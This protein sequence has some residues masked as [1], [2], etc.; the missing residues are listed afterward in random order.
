[1]RKKILDSFT[2]AILRALRRKKK[3]V[4]NQVIFITIATTSMEWRLAL[5]LSTNMKVILIEDW[6]LHWNTP[7]SKLL[8][9]QICHNSI[10]VFTA[11]TTLVSQV[12]ILTSTS[13]SLSCHSSL[14]TFLAH[15]LLPSSRLLHKCPL[16]ILPAQMLYP[17]YIF[18]LLLLLPHARAA[19]SFRRQKTKKILNIFLQ[20]L[21]GRARKRAI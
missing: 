13:T 14:H 7:R 1:M 20:W 9:I 11:Q 6:A 10:F 3:K 8:P 4:E 17:N 16:E 2:A 15:N 21:R 5:P 19:S 18:F 12:C